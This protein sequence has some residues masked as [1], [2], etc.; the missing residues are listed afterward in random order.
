MGSA[1]SRQAFDPEAFWEAILSSEPDRIRVA[2]RSLSAE[3]AQAVRAHLKKM[4]EEPGWQTAQQ[5]AAAQA[6]RV[7][8]GEAP[9]PAP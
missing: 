6:L 3:E 2:W 7:I 9:P 1:T 5:Q 4:A 8:D